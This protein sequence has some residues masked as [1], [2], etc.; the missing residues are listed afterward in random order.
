MAESTGP[1]L[2]VGAISFGNQWVFNKDPDF[3]I[4]LATGVAALILAGI[5]HIDAPIATGLA[6][7]ALITISL[8]RVQGKP[9]PAENLLRVSGLGKAA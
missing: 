6:W 9:S 3:R 7:I 2:A 8:T 4:L 5:E 1:I